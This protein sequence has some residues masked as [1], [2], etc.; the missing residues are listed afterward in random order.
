M[1]ANSLPELQAV[2]EVAN[3]KAGRPKRPAAPA[4]NPAYRR[5]SQGIGSL[6]AKQFHVALIRAVSGAPADA[7]FVPNRDDGGNIGDRID[8]QIELGEEKLAPE[9]RLFVAVIA[10][11]MQDYIGRVDGESSAA[12]RRRAQES[13]AQYFWS[14]DR[15]CLVRHCILL[16]LNVQFVRDMV[17]R[18]EE[19]VYEQTELALAKG[20]KTGV[21]MGRGQRLEWLIEQIEAGENAAQPA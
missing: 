4:V 5:M 10:K 13:A 7:C 11:A 1:S 17:S 21:R 8:M 9:I 14:R 18:G 20:R 15:R 12:D 19:Y 6:V 3:K 16:G 2:A